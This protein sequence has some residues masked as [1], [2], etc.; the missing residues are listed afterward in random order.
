M[1]AA[2]SAQLRFLT[3]AAY[4]MRQAAPHTSAHLMRRRIDLALTA[5]A[6][7]QAQGQAATGPPVP[8]AALPQTDVQRQLVCTSCGLVLMPGSDNTTLTIQSGRS[9]QKHRRK[10]KRDEK[11][12]TAASESDKNKKPHGPAAEPHAGITKVYKC[13]LC[14]RETRIVLPPPP[15]PL[16]KQ[17]KQTKQTER[18]PAAAARAKDDIKPAPA[19]A[20]TATPPSGTPKPSTAS[21]AIVPPAPAKASSNASSKKRAKNRK[22]GLLAL[23]DKS[24]SSDSSGLGGL[25]LSFDDF[26]R[27]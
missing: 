4:L 13:G 26:R 1:A 8:V 2:T 25:N 10:R 7:S 6:Q 11:T 22:A 3:D 14:R 20:Q 9:S 27:K 12:D 18:K 21:T 17:R 24:R 15:P 19:A 23:L 5:Q 16:S